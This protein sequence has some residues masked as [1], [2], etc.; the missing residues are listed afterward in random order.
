MSFLGKWHMRI[1]FGVVILFMFAAICGCGNSKAPS[2]TA[3][4][5]KIVLGDCSWDSIMVHNRIA[6]FIIEH[7]YGY[8]VDFVFGETMPILQGLQKGDVH[9]LMEAWIDNFLEAYNKALAS[10]QVV[11]LGSNF[12]DA[13]QGWYV[14][15]YLIKGDPQRGIEPVAPDLKS[16]EDLPKYWQ[17]FKDPEQPNKGRFHN[18]PPGWLVTSVNAEKIKV[19]GLEDYYVSFMTGSDTALTTSLVSAYEKGIPWLGYYW[20]PT[21]VMGKYDMYLLEEP[22]YNKEVWEQNHGCAFPS[23]TPRI[24]INRN[25]K[26]MA[27][28]VVEFLENY[29]TTLEDNNTFLAYMHD[30]GGSASDAA[31]WF[32]KQY[33]EK[34]KKWIPAEVAL[35]VEQA[36]AKAN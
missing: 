13:P 28:E 34:W 2:N 21:W 16:V 18:G 7:G 29:Q 32:L 17:L 15:T 23:C 14:P 35:K 27:P 10:G 25:L 31:L 33:P 36:L 22:P 9:I 3:G 5:A 19:Y 6:G 1:L 30:T 8:P 24:V 12:S 11:E 4:K 20:E 26:Q